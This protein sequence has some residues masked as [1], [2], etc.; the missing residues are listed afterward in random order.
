ME[1][2][3]RKRK[4]KIC[5]PSSF[6]S[7]FKMK[8]NHTTRLFPASASPPAPHWR[9]PLPG[10]SVKTA[11]RR[12]RM[13]RRFPVLPPKGVGVR[14]LE[15]LTVQTAGVRTPS[16]HYPAEH[17]GRCQDQIKE[18]PYLMG[19]TCPLFP[20]AAAAASAFLPSSLKVALP[21]PPLFTR[22]SV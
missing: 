9:L 7:P 18:C 5:Y 8:N 20:T 13:W 12:A 11:G 21:S 4:K 19:V 17:S 1:Q 2:R 10:L 22:Q 6:H 15:T 14:R 16:R 3:K